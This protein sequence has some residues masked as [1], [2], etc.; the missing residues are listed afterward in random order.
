MVYLLVL[1]LARLLCV[2]RKF[3]IRLR[4]REWHRERSLGYANTPDGYRDWERRVY[5]TT[6]APL[7]LDEC[8]LDELAK[9]L[10]KSYRDLSVSLV[11]P[12]ANKT[13]HWLLRIDGS[14]AYTQEATEDDL[15]IT[16][17]FLPRSGF[18]V[19]SAPDVFAYMRSP[20]QL[21]RHLR[22]LLPSVE[23]VVA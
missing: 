2:T 14:G 13:R 18:A 3:H 21:L 22:V 16:V 10:R 11:P 1:G 4:M 20:R 6:V 12:Q 7:D 23:K 8:I 5:G 19:F 15:Y 17:S 9:H